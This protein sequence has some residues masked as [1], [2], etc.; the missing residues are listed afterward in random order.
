M[1]KMDT[2]AQ[3]SGLV[4][5]G[6]MN[7]TKGGSRHQRQCTGGD[8]DDTPGQVDMNTEARVLLTATESG[9][10]GLDSMGG[11]EHRGRGNSKMEGY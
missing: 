3:E 5:K 4:Q 8:F 9:P 11:S 2:K 10:K 6:A 7:K 1:A